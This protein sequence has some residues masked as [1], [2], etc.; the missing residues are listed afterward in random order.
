ML[1]AHLRNIDIPTTE[2]GIDSLRRAD[3]KFNIVDD[4]FRGGKV[5]DQFYSGMAIK[6]GDELM[7]FKFTK[8]GNDAGP[9]VGWLSGVAA[10]SAY[11]VQ[12]IY[13]DVYENCW[14][15]VC[16]QNRNHITKLA[17]CPTSK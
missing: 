4:F 8:E 6:E 9:F 16:R 13:S 15:V 7:L 5:T 17:T 2:Q 3:K 10:D 12:I 11:S 1:K 14:Q